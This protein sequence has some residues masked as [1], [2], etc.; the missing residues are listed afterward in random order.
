MITPM[1]TPLLITVPVLSHSEF[2]SDRPHRLA[3]E[4][5]IPRQ[6][7]EVRK[8]RTGVYVTSTVSG[9]DKKFEFAH[10][11]VQ[12]LDDPYIAT[13]FDDSTTEFSNASVLDRIYQVDDSG[14]S[15]PGIQTSS[16]YI[17]PNGAELIF[18]QVITGADTEPIIVAAPILP[19]SD[20]DYDISAEIENAVLIS[21]FTDRRAAS[22]DQLT[23]G[24]TD[25]R[26]CW[27]DAT[28]DDLPSG[29][30]DQGLG[31][32]LWLLAREKTVPSVLSR[33]KQYAE[34]ALAWMVEDKI[35]E[36]VTVTA[37]RL[38]TPG[39]DWLALS[40]EIT[41]PFA[42]AISYRYDYNWRQLSYRLAA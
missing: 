18:G 23:D 28:L 11:P 8:R 20:A 39:N 1:I 40:I 5:I 27:M 19:T 33:A 12:T 26:G 13:C 14:N 9:D 4:T 7:V 30:A 42:P 34:Q 10:L 17:A 36:S 29:Q 16:T 31:S 21:L 24:E 22:T 3:G 38:G 35:A 2:P 41:R 32:L 15:I 37:G 6:R 25:L